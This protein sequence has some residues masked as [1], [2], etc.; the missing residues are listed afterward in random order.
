M[1]CTYFAETSDLDQSYENRKNPNQVAN[2]VQNG[3][4]KL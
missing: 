2:K 1:F 3:H 4:N